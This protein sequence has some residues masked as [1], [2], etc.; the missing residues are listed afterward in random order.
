MASSS[1]TKDEFAPQRTLSRRMTQAPTM[2]DPTKDDSVPIDSELVPSSLAVIAPILRVANEV[3][4][5]NPR[6]AYLCRFHAF[7]KAHK[8][9]PTSSGRGVRQFKTYLLHRLEKVGYFPWKNSVL[10]S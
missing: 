10:S 3:E 8:M 9:D 7:E 5:E 4:K 1:G 6:V 2:I